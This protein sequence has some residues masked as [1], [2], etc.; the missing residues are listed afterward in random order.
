MGSHYTDLNAF[1]E[2]DLDLILP[3]DMQQLRQQALTCH[4][5]ELSKQRTNVVF[6][7][8]N[9]HADILFIGEGPGVNED[10][11]GKP[12]V[13]K[14]GELLTKMIENVLEI[15]REDVYIANIV[16]CRPP[17]NRVPSTEEA[18]T[19][20]PYL[21]KQIELI[22]PKLI[23]TLGSTAYQYLTDDNTPIT[24]VRGVLRKDDEY[25]IIPTFHPSYL[26]RNP[27]AK[28]E[29]YADLLKAKSFLASIQ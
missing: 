13:G 4:L 11:Q 21:F 12:F 9:E 2:S 10:I 24:Q 3:N 18:Y 6:G 20:R 17:N 1:K 7:E 16:K 25:T 14:S 15:K 27:S 5:C 22:K 23:I 29:V 28:K 8:G 26:L 19:C